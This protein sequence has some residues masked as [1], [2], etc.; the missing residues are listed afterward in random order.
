MVEML[1]RYW[2]AVVL[3]GIAAI[4]FGVVAL[5]W[6]GP[7]VFA[8]VLLFGAYVLVDGV[9]TLASVLGRNRDGVRTGSR[10]WLIVQGIAAVLI[11]IL[12]FVWPGATTLVLL[13]LIAAWALITGVLQVVAAVRLRR[14]MRHE[15][16]L[17]LS[18]V[19]SVA[20]GIL[21]IVWPAAGALAVLTLIGAYAIL[22]GTALAVFGVRL[23]RNRPDARAVTGTRNR[24]ATA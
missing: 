20:F 23:H 24:P 7:T 10:G 14:E 11:G 22:F 8:L 1:S 4:L 12:T 2:W 13:W 21:L 19:L 3:R 16:L 6:P 18:G 9:F 15:W 17:A 5:V